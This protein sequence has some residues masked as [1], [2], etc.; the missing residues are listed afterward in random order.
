[1]RR[2]VTLP[3]FD[4]LLAQL[5]AHGRIDIGVRTTDLVAQLPRQQRQS[6]HEGTANA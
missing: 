4:T 3:Q 6:A 5:G 2:I 1:M